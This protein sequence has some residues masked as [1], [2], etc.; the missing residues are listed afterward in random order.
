M[1]A[2]AKGSATKSTTLLLTVPLPLLASSR[3]STPTGGESTAEPSA[4]TAA[5]SL[6]ARST[7]LAASRTRQRSV[8]A[9]PRTNAVR[10]APNHSMRG[11]PP[12][13]ARGS[14]GSK[15]DVGAGVY[16][17]VLGGMGVEVSV[18]T[19]DRV[20]V[21]VGTGLDV[22]V[23]AAQISANDSAGGCPALSTVPG[24][25]TQPSTLPGVTAVLPAPRFEYCQPLPPPRQ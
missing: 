11:G 9:S 12:A 16:V 10:S 4:S 2:A 17:A 22:A 15:V 6:P 19:G 8:A 5:A 25:H 7:T 23:A 21:P 18:L 1:A 3:T 24:P 20:A 13:G 14:S